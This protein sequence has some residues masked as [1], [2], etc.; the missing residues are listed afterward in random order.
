MRR[1]RNSQKV[2]AAG[3]NNYDVPGTILDL[4]KTALKIN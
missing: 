4:N 3:Y 1:Q 2:G